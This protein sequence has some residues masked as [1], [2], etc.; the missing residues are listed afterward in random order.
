MLIREV[1]FAVIVGEQEIASNSFPE[2]LSEWGTDF[3]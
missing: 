2:K 3:T 1:S